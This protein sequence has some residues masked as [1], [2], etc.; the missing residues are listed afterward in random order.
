MS[1]TGHSDAIGSVLGGLRG[2]GY[3]P[4]QLQP[5]QAAD[6]AQHVRGVG[7]LPPAGLLVG[8]QFAWL[9]NLRT[10]EPV[11]IRLVVYLVGRRSGRHYAA[12]AARWPVTELRGPGLVRAGGRGRRWTG[13]GARPGTAPGWAWLAGVSAVPG[14]GDPGGGLLHHR[15]A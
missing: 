14:A 12:R 13:T 15:P 6:T 11:H 9:H 5:V 1:T 2:V 8:T 7:A 10:G 4:G 3:E